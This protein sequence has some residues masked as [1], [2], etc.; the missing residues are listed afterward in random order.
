MAVAND[1]PVAHLKNKKGTLP[2]PAWLA[3]RGGLVLY[4]ALLDQGVPRRLEDVQSE[5]FNATLE[6][7]TPLPTIFSKA[8]LL[9]EK[10][11]FLRLIKP[12]IGTYKFHTF[13]KT[14][15][16]VLWIDKLS[17]PGIE[18]DIRKAICFLESLLHIPW[19]LRKV[20]QYLWKVLEKYS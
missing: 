14:L 17:T 2:R 4:Q 13:L 18:A 1:H 3:P 16:V 19:A 20:F 9:L 12:K 10:R 5:R 6:E 7:A 8:R 15:C 11:R